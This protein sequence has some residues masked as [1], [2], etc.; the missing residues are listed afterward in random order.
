MS[1]S[2][3]I[4]SLS[5]L[6]IMVVILSFSQKINSVSDS[7]FSPTE[8]EGFFPNPISCATDARKI[9]NCLESAKHLDL[10]RVTKECCIVLLGIPEDCFGMLFPFPVVFRF[11]LTNTC[12]LLGIIKV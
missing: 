9:P 2:K 7:A 12:K 6:L 10:K 8:E 3:K 11:I 4:M 5:I 1:G